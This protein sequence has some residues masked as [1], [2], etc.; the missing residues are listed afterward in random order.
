MFERLPDAVS[1]E[2]VRFLFDGRPMV[3]RAGDSVAAALLVAGVG[4]T[5]TT[6]V[7][8]AERAPYCLMGACFECLMVIDGIA[9]RQACMLE[10]RDGMTVE[11]QDRG[12]D[13]S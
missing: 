9:D 13:A 6:P 10:V 12:A 11:R 7:S 1:R 3:G 4:P 2:E 5:R 8:G